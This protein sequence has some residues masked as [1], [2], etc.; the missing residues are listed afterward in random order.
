MPRGDDSGNMDPV[1]DPYDRC[2]RP[3]L[4]KTGF[5]EHLQPQLLIEV[6]IRPNIAATAVT[7]GAPATLARAVTPFRSRN[8]TDALRRIIA[9]V[10][11]FCST[12]CLPQTEKQG[13]QDDPERQNSQQKRPLRKQIQ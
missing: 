8:L 13:E 11:A 9:Y 12:G 5:S 4:P 2:R 6:Y 1:T 7:P 3:L 10:D